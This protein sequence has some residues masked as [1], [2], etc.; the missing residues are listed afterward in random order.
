MPDTLTSA[1]TALLIDRSGRV[2]MGTTESGIWTAVPSS[3]PAGGS[4]TWRAFTTDDGLESVSIT[5]LA[6]GP[7]GCI[8]AV[9]LAGI[10]FLCPSGEVE[11]DRWT[12][13]PGSN[14]SERGWVNALAFA[15]TGELWAG[16][17]PEG[18]LWRYDGGWTDYSPAWYSSIGA[19]MVDEEGTLWAGTSKVWG[20]GGVR[21]LPAE[22][23]DLDW[24]TLDSEGLAVCNVFAL[25]RDSRGQLWIGGPGGVVMWQGGR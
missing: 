23:G 24:Q 17:H 10:S 25:A 6:Q 5:A 7:R 9:H 4:L 3:A 18:Y 14:L 19:L 21:Y 12:T 11:G 15:P 22:E 20:C 13:L 16:A 1:P 2:W 8:Y